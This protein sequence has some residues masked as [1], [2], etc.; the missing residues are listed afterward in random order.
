MAITSGEIV[1]HGVVQYCIIEF[2]GIFIRRVKVCII[3]DGE[4]V[5]TRWYKKGDVHNQDIHLK[6]K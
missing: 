5:S 1:L 3:V 4:H 2:R 6:A